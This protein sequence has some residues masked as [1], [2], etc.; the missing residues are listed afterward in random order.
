MN[1]KRKDD[2]CFQCYRRHLKEEQ[3]EVDQKLKR[4]IVWTSVLLM[5]DPKDDSIMPRMVVLP[6]RGTFNRNLGHDMPNSLYDRN[7]RDRLLYKL[8]KRGVIK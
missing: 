7:K 4:R 3:A 6:V 2:E 1:R 5:K 8:R